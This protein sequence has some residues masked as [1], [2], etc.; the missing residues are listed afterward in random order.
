[1]APEQQRSPLFSWL[2]MA[3]PDM[4]PAGGTGELC[5]MFLQISIHKLHMHIMEAFGEG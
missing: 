5:A 1:M 3:H 2:L 4:V